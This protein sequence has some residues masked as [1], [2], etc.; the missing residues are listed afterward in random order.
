MRFNPRPRRRRPASLALELLLILPLL[1][2]LIAGM[3][4]FS[5]I[6]TARTTLQGAAVAG[7]RVAALGGDQMAVEAAV[8]NVLG[9][10]TLSQADITVNPPNPETLPPGAPVEVIV[11]I[12]AT[13][14]APDVLRIIGLSLQPLVLEGRSVMIK[15]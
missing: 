4:E 10:G 12:P 7:A 8:R 3:V 2:A 6:L 14:V 9:T 13:K 11:T 5:L 15:E 1:I